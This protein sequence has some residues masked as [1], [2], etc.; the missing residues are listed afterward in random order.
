MRRLLYLREASVNRRTCSVQLKVFYLYALH[1]NAFAPCLYISPSHS[2]FTKRPLEE[3]ESL[4][5]FLH[6]YFYCSVRYLKQLF[7]CIRRLFAVAVLV[8]MLLNSRSSFPLPTLL[9]P[10][11]LEL[12]LL[13]CVL[14]FEGLFTVFLVSSFGLLRKLLLIPWLS[15]QQSSIFEF[16]RAPKKGL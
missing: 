14:S 2:N 16:V 9:F 5:Y 6:W 15:H 1:K 13:H 7:R 3:T 11:P 12:R 8:P 4:L 10:K